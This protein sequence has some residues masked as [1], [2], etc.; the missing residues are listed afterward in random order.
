MFNDQYSINKLK[1]VK[2]QLC[3]GS[4][5]QIGIFIAPCFSL[6]YGRTTLV[7]AALFR[8]QALLVT[9]K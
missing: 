6:G 3:S 2:H 7:P 9:I 1:D 8:S 5:F 4:N